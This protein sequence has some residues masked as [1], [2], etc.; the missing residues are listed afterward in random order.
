MQKTWVQKEIGEAIKQGFQ[1]A[2]RKLWQTMRQFRK[3]EQLPF[4]TVYS[5]DGVRLIWNKDIIWQWKEHS[6]TTVAE[7]TEVVKKLSDS[8]VR[9]VNVIHSE[10]LIVLEN[11]GLDLLTHG[12][13][14]SAQ[15]F[16]I[17]EGSHSTVCSGRC[18][19]GCWR[20]E[21]RSSSDFRSMRS[22]LGF[23]LTKENWASSLS[24]R[25]CVRV[26]GQHVIW[27]L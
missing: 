12:T 11:L 25:G 6:A 22:N 1:S 3:E 2:L 14:W 26:Y 9:G 17:L 13:A 19:P 27:G 4:H 5:G 7:V 16:P 20:R 10:F 24:S 21:F 8:Q 23:V 18:M 15:C